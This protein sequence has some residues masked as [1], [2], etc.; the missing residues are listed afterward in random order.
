MGRIKDRVEVKALQGLSLH[1]KCQLIVYGG[2]RGDAHDA[3]DEFLGGL[4]PKNRRS[5]QLVSSLKGKLKRPSKMNEQDVT[6]C[7]DQ[8]FE[9]LWP[10]AER[11]LRGAHPFCVS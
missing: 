4:Y 10:Y 8:F 2:T 11:L 1:E 5:R 6:E 9:H 3:A 7:R